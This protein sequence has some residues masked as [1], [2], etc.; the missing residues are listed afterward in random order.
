MLSRLRSIRSPGGHQRLEKSASPVVTWGQLLGMALDSHHEWPV[1][2]LD[3]LDQP[4]VRCGDGAEPSAEIA[5]RLVVQAVDP[6][7]GRAQRAR[8]HAAGLDLE[9]V[10]QR[11]ARL[12]VMR[13]AS[14][15]LD[16]QVLPQ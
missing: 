7:L 11:V 9:T 4:I 14:G 5:D 1:A 12:A 10:H 16:L 3:T 13:D 2:Q 15:A 6:N 8:E